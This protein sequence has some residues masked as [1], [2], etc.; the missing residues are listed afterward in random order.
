MGTRPFANMT[1]SA[2]QTGRTL[3]MASRHDIDSARL[4]MLEARQALED[5]ET[6]NGFAT[7]I[8][9]TTALRRSAEA[10]ETYLR[11][12]AGQRQNPFQTQ[13]RIEQGPSGTILGSWETQFEPP[14]TIR[15]PDTNPLV[16]FEFGRVRRDFYDDM[17]VTIKNMTG[18]AYTLSYIIFGYDSRAMPVN[19]AHDDLQIGNHETVVREISLHGNGL[20]SRPLSSFRLVAR[21]AR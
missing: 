19:E 1:T 13:G 14:T 15:L 2:L 7:C 9:H 12:S 21:S 20:G 10:T 3:G 16:I 11:L 17:T 4:R 8:E 5:Y 18:E 6:F